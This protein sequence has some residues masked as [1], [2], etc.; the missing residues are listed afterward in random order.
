MQIT[1]SNSKPL[2]QTETANNYE[3]FRKLNWLLT[4]KKFVIQ[5]SFS[6]VLIMLFAFYALYIGYIWLFI[7]I[8]ACVACLLGFFFFKFPG[9]YNNQLKKRWEKDF[10]EGSV[11]K[12]FFYDNHFEVIVKGSCLSY[13]YS[14]I[15]KIIRTRD[16]Y[17]LMMEKNQAVI[18]V[19][20][21]CTDELTAY[22]EKIKKKYGL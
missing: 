3:E 5:I 6:V 9:R 13:K 12:V 7:L 11:F 2:Y 16:N 15:K 19:K 17:Y 1:S 20:K 18:I 14:D 10:S 4:K 22:L 8:T 21:N